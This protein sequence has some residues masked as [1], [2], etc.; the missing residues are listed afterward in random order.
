MFAEIPLQVR[1]YAVVQ[2]AV[3]NGTEQVQTVLPLGFSFRSQDGREVRATGESQFVSELYQHGG[4]S[5]A[6]KLVT[7]YEKA[8]YGAERIRSNNG[9]EQRRQA[10]LTMGGPAGVKAAAA[11]SAIVLVR[12]R[13]KPKDSTD[14]ALFFFTSGRPLGPGTF[15]AQVG[16]EIF[17]FAAEPLP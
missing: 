5:D 9:Y 17:E 3:I 12:T 7:T 13:L 16:E 11:A 2:V 14:G 1:G 8:L 4:R 6:I 15:R 10:A